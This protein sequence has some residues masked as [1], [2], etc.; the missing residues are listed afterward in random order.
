[1]PSAAGSSPP[2]SKSKIYVDTTR[3]DPAIPVEFFLPKDGCNCASLFERTMEKISIFTPW[4]NIDDTRFELLFFI[5]V[6]GRLDRFLSSD[7]PLDDYQLLRS[8]PHGSP[9]LTD[10]GRA[11]VTEDRAPRI[12]GEVLLLPPTIAMKRG[13]KVP[14]VHCTLRD[15]TTTPNEHGI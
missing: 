10:E 3:W 4:L 15:E 7:S 6:G 8:C 5:S 1:S 13:F 2:K 14:V 11:V 12:F 9:L